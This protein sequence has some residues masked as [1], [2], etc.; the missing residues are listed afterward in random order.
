MNVSGIVAVLIAA[1]STANNLIAGRVYPGV[2][3]QEAGYPSIAVNLITPNPTNTKTQASDLDITE[4]Q[5]DVYGSTYST[6][7]AASE[8]V[9]SA[10]EYYSGT[11]S[12]TGGVSVN[13]AH[14][15]Y[16]SERDG[17]VEKADVF[18]RIC[19]YSISI[20]R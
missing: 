1:D 14:I 11:V 19:E 20:R 8:A 12:L 4:V 9:R 17:F 2:V 10:L 5:V 13:V 6:T 7:A 15:E 18:R 16:K 3:K